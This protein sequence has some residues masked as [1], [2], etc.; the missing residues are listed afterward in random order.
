MFRPSRR[1]TK[2]IAPELARELLRTE[3]RGVLAVIG[4]DGY[5]YA[6]PVDYLYIQEKNTVIFHGA[7]SG[8]KLEAILR[9]DKV[10]FTVYGHET[11]SRESWAPFMRSTVIF[12]RCHVIQDANEVLS[13]CRALSLKYYPDEVSVDE[14]LARI[15]PVMNVFEITIEHMTG[16]EIQEK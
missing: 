1:I 3:R 16:K 4:D 12:G 5:P 15:G 10:C 7:K 2:E 11:F 14:K 9:C 6:V 13:L 8:H